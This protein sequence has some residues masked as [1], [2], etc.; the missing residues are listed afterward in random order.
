MKQ[1][2]RQSSFFVGTVFMNSAVTFSFL[3]PLRECKYFYRAEHF[4]EMHPWSWLD[5]DLEPAEAN[6]NVLAG[7]WEMVVCFAGMDL[8]RL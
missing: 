7:L 4:W 1:G 8:K 3:T 2:L 6:D 5:L